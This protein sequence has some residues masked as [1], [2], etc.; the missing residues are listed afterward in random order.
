MNNE[1]RIDYEQ[2]QK[3][4]L[5]GYGVWK[6]AVIQNEIFNERKVVRI[7]IYCVRGCPAEPVAVPSRIYATIR[8][9]KKLIFKYSYETLKQKTWYR[10]KNN[11]KAG[12]FFYYDM[13]SKR[14]Y[15]EKITISFTMFAPKSG[16]H[17]MKVDTDEVRKQVANQCFKSIRNN[18]PQVTLKFRD[19]NFTIYPSILES[20]S[21][22]LKEILDM[23]RGNEQALVIDFSDYSSNVGEMI[24]EILC[25]GAI[26][27]TALEIR[28]QHVSALMKVYELGHKYQ[29][30]NVMQAAIEAFKGIRPRPTGPEVFDFMQLLSSQKSEMGDEF[31]DNALQVEFNPNVVQQSQN[32]PQSKL[33]QLFNKMRI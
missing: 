26:H 5:D 2:E 7:N 4:L 33:R 1:Y 22:F 15:G 29:M 8:R 18:E 16:L 6:F 24:L 3:A 11:L 19:K 10:W 9:E 12:F 17:C 14:P 28:A 32:K 25:S 21:A 23:Q 27:E 13:L 31:L 30:D 20:H